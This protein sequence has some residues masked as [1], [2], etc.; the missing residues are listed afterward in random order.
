MPHLRKLLSPVLLVL[1]V[2]A[3]GE[4]CCAPP[5]EGAGSRAAQFSL[6]LS[7]SDDG[8]AVVE[9]PSYRATIGADGNLHSLRVGE[10]EM[11]DDRVAISL[12][13]FFYA[14][15]PR[16]LTK[17]SQTGQALQATDGTYLARYHFRDNEIQVSLVNRGAKPVPYFVVLAPSVT[18][19]QNSMTGEVAAVP[20][21][22]AWGSARF[23]TAGG[24]YLE[25]AGGTRVWG[26][27]LG[28]Q[29]WEVTEVPAGGT[30]EIF[31]RLGHGAA[32][33][34][35]LEQLLSLR[36]D[37]VPESG[38]IAKGV[39]VEVNVALDNR[40]HEDV[41][42]ALSIELSANRNDMVLYT[43]SSLEM[44]AQQVTEKQFR[45]R[46]SEPDFYTMKIA[47]VAGHREIGEVRAA[48]GYR[49]NEIR[50]V[51]G[52]PP[53][54]QEFWQRVLDEAGA[55]APTY[56]IRFEPRLS[57]RGVNV[58]VVR[59]RSLDGSTIHGWYVT[60]TAGEPHPAL[61]YL[62]GYGAKPI[63]PPVAL[64]R[65]GWVVLAIDVRGNPVDRVR[66][67][68][69]ED[70]SREGIESPDTFVYREIVGHALKAI[71]FLHSREEADPRAIAV[72]GV[73]EGG[74]LGIMLGALSPE[75][76]AVAAD[77]PMLVDFPLSLHSA[78]WPYTE[79]ARYLQ[80]HPGSRADIVHTL[81]YFDAVNFAPDV[82]CPILLS[83]GL[84][85]RVSLPAAVFGLYNVLPEPKQIVTFPD[86]GHEGGGEDHRAYLLDWLQQT[87]GNRSDS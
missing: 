40:S 62:S 51:V 68:P 55:E 75:V 21:N 80:K 36:A 23:S 49:V 78:S 45:W 69:F 38:L 85:D 53:D 34:A 7:V 61:L 43:S 48:A 79:I 9:T 86:V 81:S 52:R 65:R 74:G 4:W 16:R 44:P 3:V 42:G 10:M 57:G 60:P 56:R 46:V 54:F 29:V 41:S 70:Y 11:L 27:W 5:A 18:M 31:F 14:D 33:K 59:Y 8:G 72:V 66:P 73:S 71:K 6:T 19:V 84:L 67:R 30:R 87:L 35:T 82:H 17:Q 64:A 83:V 50:P 1:A 63:S 13:S 77:A 2:A 25:L 76:A 47:A 32:P 15:G 28:R 22:E 12:G 26:P 58:W 20:A 24:T 37:V 39:P